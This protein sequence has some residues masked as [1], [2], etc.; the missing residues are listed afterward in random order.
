MQTT[1]SL[2]LEYGCSKVGTDQ[3]RRCRKKLRSRS[4]NGDY[5]ARQFLGHDFTIPLSKFGERSIKNIR[6]VLTNW[7]TFQKRQ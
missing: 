4:R 7:L 6:Q 2:I 3:A 5:L 1:E